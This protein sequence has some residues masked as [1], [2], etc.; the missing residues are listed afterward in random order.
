MC[1]AMEFIAIESSIALF[2]SAGIFCILIDMTNGSSRVQY[3]ASEYLFVILAIVGVFFILRPPFIFGG[4]GEAHYIGH[5]DVQGWKPQG[6]P[7]YVPPLPGHHEEAPES[8]EGDLEAEM[9]MPQHNNL[10]G[11]YPVIR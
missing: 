3:K 5:W 10:I 11:M 4:F 6:V 8:V 2:F 1:Y 7:A 9:G